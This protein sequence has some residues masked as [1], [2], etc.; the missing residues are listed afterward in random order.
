MKEMENDKCLIDENMLASSSNA[1]NPKL[2][3]HKKIFELFERYGYEVTIANLLICS[4]SL[5]NRLHK[6]IR[7]YIANRITIHEKFI[8]FKNDLV[9]IFSSHKWQELLS[10]WLFS[11]DTNY[12]KKDIL[13]GFFVFNRFSNE[14]DDEDVMYD[15]IAD[16]LDVIW[17]AE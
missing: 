3:I 9:K 17:R 12:N 13:M 2:A 11:L 16:T 4:S 14:V 15:R 10:S 5:N 6:D 8:D 7:E 1:Q